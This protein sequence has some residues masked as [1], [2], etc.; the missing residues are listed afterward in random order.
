MIVQ[1]IDKFDPTI[2]QQSANCDVVEDRQMLNVL[3]KPDSAGMRANWNAK[4]C[5]HQQHRNNLIHTRKPTA[6]YLAIIESLGLQELFEHYTVLTML[7][8]GDTDRRER[9]S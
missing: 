7:A 5:R 1:M 6:V 2:I 8:R 4:F 3:A 9:F